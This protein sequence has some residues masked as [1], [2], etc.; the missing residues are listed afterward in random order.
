MQIRIKGYTFSLAAPYEPGHSLTAGEAQALNDLRAEN[1]QNNFR[2]KVNDQ[3]ARL[4]P[5]S[6]LTQS[7]LEALQLQLTSYDAGYKF[8]E[9]PGRNRTGDIEREALAIARE[10]VMRDSPSHLTTEEI[11]GLVKEMVGLSAVLE[12]ARTRVMANRSALAGGM[13]S[14]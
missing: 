2:D 9:K 13:D 6:L 14:L 5:G 4:S 3:V 12:E 1:I 7:V 8:N 11:E 10:R